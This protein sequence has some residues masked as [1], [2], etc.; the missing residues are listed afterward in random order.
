[1]GKP[2]DEAERPK[3]NI[4]GL[5]AGVQSTALLLLSAQGQIP[6]F[7]AAI[8]A[9]TGWEPQIVYEHL[10][11][12][13]TEVAEPAG[14][15]IYRVSSGNVR[16]DALNPEARFATM[17][18]YVLGPDGSKGMVRRQCTA[19]Y[20]VKPIKRKVRE[21]LGYPHPKP[22]PKG[23]FATQAIGI[24]TDEA[25]R[26]N[27]SDVKYARHYWPLLDMDWSR[28]DCLDYLAKN[29]FPK[30]P[31][32]ACIGCPFHGNSAWRS[33][34]DN[35]HSEWWDAVDFD[36]RIRHGS[37]RANATGN[38]LRGQAF[39]H[40]SRLPLDLAPIDEIVKQKPGFDVF[41]ISALED[42]YAEDDI[43]GCSPFACR[44]D[45]LGPLG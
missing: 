9:D 5:G 13:E 37:A 19:E 4:L 44:A 36:A 20:K 29:G 33:L 30:T 16:A 22:I 38:P 28:Q 2:V 26:A 32:S 14:I 42:A 12:L 1:M 7:D 23:V 31:K 18:F 39:L 3:L 43:P 35:Y 41:D 34:R 24:S 27:L 10:D 6:K 21:L 25:Q 15:P 40:R 45:A 11:R 17:P 8:F